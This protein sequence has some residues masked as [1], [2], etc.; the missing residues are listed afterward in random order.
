M[1]FCPLFQFRN[2]G[3]E[4]RRRQVF[5]KHAVIPTSQQQDMQVY[6]PHIVKHVTYFESIRLILKFEFGCFSHGILSIRFPLTP[7]KW[8]GRHPAKERCFNCLPT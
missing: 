5:T 3:I 1:R 7:L 6:L 8:V 2:M 4:T